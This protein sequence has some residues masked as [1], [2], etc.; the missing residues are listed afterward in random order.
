MLSESK[1]TLFSYK[2]QNFHRDTIKTNKQFYYCPSSWGVVYLLTQILQQYSYFRKEIVSRTQ[3]H[4]GH[5]EKTEWSRTWSPE[6]QGTQCANL[7]QVWAIHLLFRRI[8]AWQTPTPPDFIYFDVFL[9]SFSWS[10]LSLRAPHCPLSPQ[11]YL[12]ILC[13]YQGLKCIS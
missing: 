10:F 8:F 4:I 1:D 3:I 6:D 5:Q 13:S 2:F 7:P 12:H 9:H 11:W